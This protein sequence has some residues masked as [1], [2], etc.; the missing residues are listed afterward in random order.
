MDYYTFDNIEPSGNVGY[1]VQVSDFDTNDPFIIQPNPYFFAHTPTHRI[2][3][4]AQTYF[5]NY[6]FTGTGI[7]FTGKITFNGPD[8][9]VLL[10]VSFHIVDLGQYPENTQTVLSVRETDFFAFNNGV[11]RSYPLSDMNNT[12]FYQIFFNV[13]LESDTQSSVIYSS[14][15]EYPT[16]DPITITRIT[17]ISI[18]E[19]TGDATKMFLRIGHIYTKLTEP[20]QMYKLTIHATP[21]I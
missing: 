13:Y 6:N 14:S 16:Y 9:N 15:D 21:V 5:N 7:D 10:Y 3:N 2:L 4:K 18:P 12:H 8:D 20:T 19:Y 1:R 17:L 11:E